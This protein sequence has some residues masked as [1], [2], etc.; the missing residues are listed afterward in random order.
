METVFFAISESWIWLGP[1]EVLCWGVVA[2]RVAADL[3]RG[4]GEDLRG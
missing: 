4:L 1:L 2:V 3:F